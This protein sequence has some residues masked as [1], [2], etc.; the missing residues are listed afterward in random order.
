MKK[1]KKITKKEAA[2]LLDLLHNEE[3]EFVSKAIESRNQRDGDFT[4][5]AQDFDALVEDLNDNK[6]PSKEVVEAKK[7]FHKL[8]KDMNGK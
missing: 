8:K 5:N 7:R 6:P 4:L 1:T 3:N 2:R